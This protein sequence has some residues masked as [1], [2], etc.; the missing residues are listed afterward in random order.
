MVVPFVWFIRTL[1]EKSGKIEAILVIAPKIG[2]PTK[3]SMSIV[4]LLI[5]FSLFDVEQLEASQEGIVLSVRSTAEGRSCPDCQTNSS[6]VNSCYQRT[7][8]DLPV[9]GI[10][11]TLRLR[12]RRFFCD[13]PACRRKT[14]AEAV[15]ELALPFAR[16]TVRLTEQLRQLGFA[17]GAEQAARSATALKM[18]CSADTFLRL[19]RRTPSLLMPHQPTWE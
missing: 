15:P 3:V 9:S 1:R 12:V 6:R 5:P 17:I 7:V 18:A 16:K 19:I 11:L 2:F 13:N 4:S 14:F 8:K 10:P